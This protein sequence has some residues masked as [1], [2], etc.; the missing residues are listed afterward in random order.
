MQTLK[1]HEHTFSA[2]VCRLLDWDP[3]E[4]PMAG[5]NCHHVRQSRAEPA[6]HTIR[7]I[8]AGG[9][10]LPRQHLTSVLTNAGGKP[11]LWPEPTDDKYST[12]GTEAVKPGEHPPAC[13]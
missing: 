3:K 5:R 4:G 9:C 12:S 7:I 11:A 10:S 2:R 8:S 1:L 6:A 13:K